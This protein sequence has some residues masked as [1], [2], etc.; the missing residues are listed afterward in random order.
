ME[1]KKA[2]G[3]STKIIIIV[4]IILIALLAAI[5]VILLMR[6][7]Q[8]DVSD[9]N[10]PKIDYSTDAKVMLDEDSLQAAIDE[11]V[12]NAEN[13]MVALSYQNDAYSTDG[14][15]FS[16]YI[17]N[18]AANL[19]DMFITIYADSGLTDQLFL[20]GL[21]PPGSG[22]EEI[23][24][25]HALEPGDHRVYVA[26]TQVDTDEETGEQVIGNQVMHTIEFHVTQ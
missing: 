17:A 5:V 15:T 13:G 24:L 26:V 9:G 19:Y 22:F 7:P 1:T 10:I 11:A 20:S 18:D 8:T 6:Q 3:Q 23:T 25:D 2:P 12:Y 21:I 4:G 16:C 14:K